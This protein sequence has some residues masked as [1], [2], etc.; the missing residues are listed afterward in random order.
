MIQNDLHSLLDYVLIHLLPSFEQLIPQIIHEIHLSL[1]PLRLLEAI[2]SSML[3][4]PLPRLQRTERSPLWL[5]FD[6]PEGPYLSQHLYHL[7][8]FHDN[9][10]HCML[11]KESLKIPLEFLDRHLLRFHCDFHRSTLLLYLLFLYCG[12]IIATLTDSV[13]SLARACLF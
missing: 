13:R 5:S 4:L 12:V 6:L 7:F 3:H 10:S 2:L 1:V 8:S 9:L 11:L